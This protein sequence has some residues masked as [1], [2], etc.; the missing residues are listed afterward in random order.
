MNMAKRFPQDGKIRESIVDGIFYPAEEEE[1]TKLIEN[2]LKTCKGDTGDAFAIISPHAGYSFAGEFIAS[3]FKAAMKRPVKNVVIVAP[4]HTDPI[5]NIFLPESKF[6]LTPLGAIE[7]NQS[8]I[9]ELL[10]C[11]TNILRQ[12][13]PH[14]EE[15]CIE[16]HLPFI[17][18]LFPE[19]RIVPILLGSS[20]MSCI[21]LLSNALQLTFA[22]SYAQTLFVVSANMTSHMTKYDTDEETDKFLDMIKRSDWKGIAEARAKG[23]I[24]SCG[25][26][27]ISTILSFNEVEFSA[28]IIATGSSGEQSEEAGDVVTYAAIALENKKEK[29]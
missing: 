4:V 24:S 28:K 18:Y 10:S 9:E 12:D 8:I 2:L 29:T 25:A 5:S 15:H 20:T 16:V 19:A 7:V 21:K 22:G 14:L 27:C 13:L 23:V 1:L 11:S 3:S 26:A 6:F 17:R